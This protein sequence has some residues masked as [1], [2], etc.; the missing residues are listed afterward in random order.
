MRHGIASLAVDGLLHGF[1][2]LTRPG[3]A[4]DVVGRIIRAQVEQLP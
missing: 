2:D 1:D 3:D 4:A